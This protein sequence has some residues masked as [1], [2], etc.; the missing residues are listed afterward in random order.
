MEAA[1]L[2]VLILFNGVFAM[3]EVA[4]I[5]SRKV[6]LKR[7][8]DEGDV[9]ARSA[10][11]L[12]EHPTRSLSTIQIGITSIGILNG[13]VGE[14]AFARPLGEWVTSLGAPPGLSQVL[15]T[16]LVVIVV[17]YLSIVFGE[18]V[19][20][21][22]GQL[23]PE[24][25]LRI[26]ATPL[27]G[28]GVISGPFVRLL[29]AST[30]L[31]LRALGAHRPT[32]PSVTEEEIHLMIDEGSE[33]G[34]IEDEERRM[35]HN[36][37][38][39]DDRPVASLMLPRSDIVALDIH[40]APE[41]NLRLIQASD[42]ARYP[43][44]RGSMEHVIG[45]VTTRKLLLQLRSTGSLDLGTVMEPPVFVP[46]TLDAMSLLKQF[47][48]SGGQM[49]FAVDEYGAVQ[50]LLT[51]H[52]LLEAITGEFRAPATDESWAV[53]RSDGSWL[54]DGALPVPDASR[55]LGW[56]GLPAEAP[57]RYQTLGGLLLVLMGRIPTE[58]ES[59]EWEDWR[60][61]VVD[62]D[63]KRVDKVL[64]SRRPDRDALSH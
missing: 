20:K 28:L 30:D 54:L 2:I 48:A 6:R 17:T 45:V 18:L 40:G 58:G 16:A 50:G 25:L 55:I 29:S 1:L 35:V 3:T 14:A 57:G 59:T 19:P 39:L 5:A 33:A 11:A 9:L 34:V 21:R 47:R 63:G 61:E 4:V 44:Y 56:T 15:A 36:L 8:A 26:L 23:N 46:S 22:I 64:A 24:P 49:A 10:L 13:I 51:V 43:V 38:G 42:H 37:F 62:M 12:A 52:D 31:I 27:I 32:A 60:L 53:Q 41:E 7:S